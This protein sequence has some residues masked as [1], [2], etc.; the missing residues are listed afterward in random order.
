MKNMNFLRSVLL[1]ILGSYVLLLPAG[2]Q[3]KKVITYYISTNGNDH[4][5]GKKSTPLKTIHRAQC[6][7]ASFWGKKEIHFVFQDGVHYLD[8]TLVIRSD[9]SGK[10]NCPVVY[11]A[12][13]TGKAVLSGCR[14]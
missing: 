4:H 6:L 14:K 10:G 9:Q 2:I 8:S 3:D 12:A 1:G 7:A 13:H 5:D 11:R